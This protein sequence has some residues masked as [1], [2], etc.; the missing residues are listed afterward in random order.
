MVPTKMRRMIARS[1]KDLL[2]R[3]FRETTRQES[4]GKSQSCGASGV[5]SELLNRRSD[6]KYEKLL[7]PVPALIP[8][9]ESFIAASI[10][11]GPA[12]RQ[13]SSSYRVSKQSSSHCY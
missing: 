11:Q 8:A 1:I 6:M 3:D 13:V 2:P 9:A 12:S 10:P 5:L 4:R 7:R